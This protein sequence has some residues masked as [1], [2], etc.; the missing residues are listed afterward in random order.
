M[1]SLLLLATATDRPVCPSQVAWKIR[2]AMRRRKQGISAICEDSSDLDGEGKREWNR[3]SSAEVAL[4]EALVASL[5]VKSWA[6]IAA[7][8]PGR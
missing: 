6:L 2:A 1:W 3:W 7:R 8:L 4:L 5:G